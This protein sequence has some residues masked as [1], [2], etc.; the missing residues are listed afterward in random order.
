MAGTDDSAGV[1][2]DVYHREEMRSEIAVLFLDGEILLMIPHYG[3]EDFVRE[4]EKGGIEVTLDDGGKLVEIDDEF[5]Q[6]GILVD[7]ETAAL[8]MSRQF[9]VD[10]FLALRR[11]DDDAVRMELL[12]IAGKILDTNSTRAEKAMAASRVAR[13]NAG[14]GKFQW[15]AFEHRDDPADGADEA[16]A[17]EAGP[18]HG[19]G[20]GAVRPSLICLAAWYSP[21]GV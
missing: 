14:D 1:A 11:A 18:G 12:L 2:R 20:P 8:G 15:L 17:L 9:P 10:F 3:D 4:T 16:R 6:R 13:G 19:T 7:L 21:L 5:S